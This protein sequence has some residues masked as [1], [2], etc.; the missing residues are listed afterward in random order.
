MV[1]KVAIIRN[2]PVRK[3]CII[4]T[5]LLERLLWI[6]SFDSSVVCRAICRVALISLMKPMC[7]A[8]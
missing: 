3:K 5:P 1:A 2:N 8:N 7:V 4:M 6:S